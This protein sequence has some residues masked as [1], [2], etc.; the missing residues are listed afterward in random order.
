MEM[1][2][3]G[4]TG[5]KVSALGYGGAP[6]GYLK[7]DPGESAVLLNTLLDRG[8][9][10]IDTAA[11]Y[12]G[13]EEVIGQ[14]VSHRRNEFV[15]ISKCP[16][17]MT[18]GADCWSAPKITASVERSLKRLRTDHLD[19]VLL[20]S[21]GKDVLEQ[22]E[23]LGAL[24]KAKEAGKVS[25]VGYSGDNEAAAFAAGLS[26]I[27]VV[28]TSVNI[29]DQANLRTLLPEARERGIGIIAKRPLANGAW[30]TLSEQKGIYADYAKTYTERF[31]RMDLSL[32]A[33]EF[34]GEASVAWPEIALRFTLSQPGVHVAIVGTC[35]LAHAERNLESVARGPLPVKAC[36]LIR[37]AFS[38]AE[39]ISGKPWSGEI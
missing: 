26:G 34:S 27:S 16:D 22:G 19:V 2:T 29:C 24:L 1:R 35:H 12:A 33:L 37:A 31:R 15:L 9:N 21:C 7:S 11:G 20:H 28:E 39:R 3:L 10:V 4:N 32:S 36:E 23:A 25:F 38:E 18:D 14:S 8:V 13:S 30:R 17:Q 6:M 5:L